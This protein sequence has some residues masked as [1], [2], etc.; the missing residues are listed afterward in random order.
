MLR[1]H[2][3]TLERNCDTSVYVLLNSEWP[4]VENRAKRY[5]GLPLTSAVKAASIDALGK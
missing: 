1:K 3:I 2:K 4:D 5:L